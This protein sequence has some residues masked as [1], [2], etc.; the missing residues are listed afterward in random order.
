M[1]ITEFFTKYNGKYVDYDGKFGS[2]CVDLMRTYFKQCLGW[3][4]YVLPGATYAKQIFQNAFTSQY[5]KKIY[6]T[7]TGVPQEG[8]IVF[9]GYY[10][11]VTGWAGHVA[12][13]SKGDVNKFTSFD[14][15]YP[16]GTPCHFQD[17]SY[18]GVLG[19]LRPKK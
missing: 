9:W 18:R 5:F 1:T 12:I 11:L 10:P 14:Q 15:N 3:S 16:S 13:F 7:P 2:Q 6:N 19:W 17:H 4:G 8:D